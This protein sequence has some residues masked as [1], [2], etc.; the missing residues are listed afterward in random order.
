MPITSSAPPQPELVFD[1]TQPRATDPPA[2]WKLYSGRRTSGRRAI[3]VRSHQPWTVEPVGSTVGGLL[4]H[5][6]RIRPVETSTV[7]TRHPSQL[8]TA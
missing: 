3:L 2:E 8:L 4:S 7:E 6:A 1:C 5:S